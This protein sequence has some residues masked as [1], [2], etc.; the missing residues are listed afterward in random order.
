LPIDR[1]PR[2][3]ENPSRGQHRKEGTCDVSI[4]IGDTPR[5]RVKKSTVQRFAVGSMSWRVLPLQE[6]VA[7]GSPTD[8]GVGG[9]L[10]VR[11]HAEALQRLRDA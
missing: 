9:R 2:H 3:R 8:A 11:E 5:Q 7:F 1:A 4:M 10:A 6:V